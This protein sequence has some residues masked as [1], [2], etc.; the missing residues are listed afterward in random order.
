M[1]EVQCVDGCVLSILPVPKLDR[2][3]VAYEVTLRLLL[4][5]APFGEVGECSRWRLAHTAER[6]RAAQAQDGPAAFP[7][8]GADVLLDVVRRLAGAEG[9]P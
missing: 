4:D 9:A 1:A 7:V 8:A 3:G 2:G 5:G 6:L